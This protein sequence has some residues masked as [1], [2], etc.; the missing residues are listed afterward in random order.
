MY[1]LRWFCRCSVDRRSLIARVESLTSYAIF[2]TEFG[3]DFAGGACAALCYVFQSLTKA[4]FRIGK[5]GEV[6]EALVGDGV[7]DDGFGFAVDGEDDGG[8]R[9]FLRRCIILTELLRK[10]VRGWMSLVMSIMGSSVLEVFYRTFDFLDQCE[11]IRFAPSAN[12]HS[13]GETA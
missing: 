7:L 1:R 6:E 4:F 13:C 11:C 9:V 10:V 2:L 12:A 8:R 5:C 3:E